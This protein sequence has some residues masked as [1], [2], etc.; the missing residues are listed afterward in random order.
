M[1]AETQ[2]V[3]TVPLT[4]DDYDRMTADTDTRYELIDGVLIEMPSPT[5][6]HQRVLRR[7]FRLLDDYVECRQ[8]G[9]VFFAPLDVELSAYDVVQPDLV[10]VLTPNSG[11]VTDKRIVGTPDL[12]VE[13]SSPVTV[14]RDQVR[15]LR[16]YQDSGIGEYWFID[17]P[18]RTHTTWFLRNGQYEPLPY[19]RDGHARSV[20]FPELVIDLGALF[21][22]AEEQTH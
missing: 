2:T 7:Y 15:K 6:S 5:V 8:I 9:E 11:I 22:A 10:F 3:Q 18:A 13:A 1:V 4:V 20:L 12:V 14:V 16:L 17:I 19:D 21:D